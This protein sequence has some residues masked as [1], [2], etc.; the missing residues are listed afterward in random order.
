MSARERMRADAVEA[1]PAAVRLRW[2]RIAAIATAA[3][4]LASCRS[5]PTTALVS[6]GMVAAQREMSD[7]PSVAPTPAASPAPAAADA[8]RMISAA[9][10]P[11]D[12]RAI[13]PLP[14]PGDPPASA[15]WQAEV[16][17]ASAAVADA[18]V[19]R[20][21]LEA[22]CPPLPRLGRRLCGPGGC[23]GAC[24]T[25][26]CGPGCPPAACVACEAP[27]PLVGPYLVCDGGDA[28][29]P[30]MPVGEDGLRNLTAGDTVARFRPA[31]EMPDSTEVRLVTSNCACVFA[32][33]F[34]AVRE[35]TR[36]LEGSQP[37]GPRGLALD[38]GVELEQR[39]EPVCGKTQNL[40]LE[41]ARKAL[42]GVAV[43]ER[44]GPLAV[45]QGDVP[46][47]DDGFAGPVERIADQTPE[48]ERQ[49][50]RPL[51]QVGFD[52]PIAWTCI[53]AANVLLNTQSAQVVAVDRGTATL[54]FEQPGRAELTLC[55]RAGTDTARPGEELD[56]TIFMLNSGDRPLTGIVLA[57]AIPARL[58]YIPDSAAASLPADISTE[59]GDDGS[60]VLKWRLRET[61]RPGESGFVRFRTTVK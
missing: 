58:E 18:A 35:V 33:R 21:G 22:P 11:G 7:G 42:P 19:V 26:N 48:L 57:D 17:P 8:P 54:R 13:V 14:P 39:R 61:L 34:G 28:C 47:E 44:I 36:P 37:E 31:D 20:T 46:H 50:Q 1:A 40:A 38:A 12:D 4:T 27:P 10:P 2:L 55:K 9:E 51:V 32:P 49:R 25:G 53:K 52:V 5:L 60:V 59:T 24:P 45:D 23:R 15:G 3:V 30:A 56:F 6:T 29:R 43:E 41:A 16:R